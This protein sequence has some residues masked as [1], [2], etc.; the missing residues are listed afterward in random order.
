MVCALNQQLLA[1][2]LLYRITNHSTTGISPCKLIMQRN[3]HTLFTL[4]LQ[5][6]EQSV[7]EKQSEQ[8]LS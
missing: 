3:F 5:N 7:R 8:K 2:L 1:Y 6:T 4:L